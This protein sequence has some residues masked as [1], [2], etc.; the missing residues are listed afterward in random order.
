MKSFWSKTMNLSYGFDEK[1]Y[2][3]V[4]LSPTYIINYTQT[5]MN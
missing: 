1:Q 3:K 4:A 5:I 2:F